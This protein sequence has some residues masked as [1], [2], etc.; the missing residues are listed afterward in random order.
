VKLVPAQYVRTAAENQ[1]CSGPSR[2]CP[3]GFRIATISGQPDIP[4]TG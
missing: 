3:P 4:S 1:A 2:R